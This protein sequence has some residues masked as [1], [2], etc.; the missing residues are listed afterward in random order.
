VGR[1]AVATLRGAPG[2]A[3]FVVVLA[4]VLSL[5]VR[6]EVTSAQ[7]G[8]LSLVY[9]DTEKPGANE[10]WVVSLDGASK[11]QV[12][13]FDKSVRPLALRGS[14]LALAHDPDLALLD[15]GGG[16]VQW[17]QAGR[18]VAS[19]I[20]AENGPVYFT[21]QV[22]C[23]P[24]EAKTV[25]GRVDAATGVRTDIVELEVPGAELLR[26][27]AAAD[28]LTLVPRGC[29]PGV[30]ALKT[31]NAKTGAEKA[32]LDVEGCGWAAISPTGQQALIS[33][34]ACMTRTSPD[35]TVYDLPGGASREQYFSVDAPSPHPFVYAPD[36]SRAAYGLTLGLGLDRFLPPTLPSTSRSGG[37]WLLDPAS[38]SSTK[39]WQDSGQ[40]SWAIAWSPDGTRLAVASVEAQGRCGYFVVDVAAN[41]AKRVDGVIGCGQNGTVIGFATVQ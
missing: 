36:G 5:T 19:A 37:I 6:P 4:S 26:Y 20:I 27:D 33:F 12:A 41:E 23:G 32:S 35:V 10:V 2:L 21:T 31:L 39:L 3:I 8:L 38:L 13:T 15:L 11:R 40:E 18:R 29:D 22:G 16:T 25:L 14:L 28:E 7:P 30:S 9:L 24:V 1:R 34:A 17:S